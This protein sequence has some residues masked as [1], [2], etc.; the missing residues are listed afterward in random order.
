M[1]FLSSNL[2]FLRKRRKLSQ[3]QLADDLGVKRSN[4]AAYETKNVEPRLALINDIARY[5]EMPL[6]HL[7]MTNL[8]A[9]EPEELSVV[10]NGGNALT[11]DSVTEIKE[12]SDKIK[13]VLDGFRIFY[14]FKREMN[15]P[16]Q[17]GSDGDIENFLVFI[18][19]MS[20]YNKLIEQRVS[21]VSIVPPVS[22]QLG[23]TSVDS[24]R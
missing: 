19:H 7:I 2:R 22:Q 21:P 13:R 23:Q 9:I 10:A 15:D 14:E 12:V 5:F 8:T 20:E 1:N 17:L 11:V 4:I 6:E 3:Q 18:N 24:N 16:A